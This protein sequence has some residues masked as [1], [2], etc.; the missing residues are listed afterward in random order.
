MLDGWNFLRY[1]TSFVRYLLEEEA[2]NLSFQ[3][4]IVFIWLWHVHWTLSNEH[5]LSLAGTWHNTCCHC[6][7]RR[8]CH[9]L[10]RRSCYCRWT[11]SS[12]TKESNCCALKMEVSVHI[13]SNIYLLCDHLKRRRESLN[14]ICTTVHRTTDAYAIKIVPQISYQSARIDC[15]IVTHIMNC[16]V[17]L[18]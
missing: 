14:E 6:R 2:K 16:F 7:R 17:R 18:H 13:Y 12:Q 11:E 4:G 1:S 3:P 15:Y 9:S 8:R 10:R 5:C